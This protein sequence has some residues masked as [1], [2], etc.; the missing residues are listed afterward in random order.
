M[1]AS[2]KVERANAFL[3]RNKNT[4]GAHAKLSPS[5]AHRWV[6]C[7]KSV[8][9]CRKVKRKPT[10]DAAAQGTFLHEVAEYILREVISGRDETLQAGE[11]IGC[12]NGKFTLD[13]DNVGHVSNYVNY[14][15]DT[16]G[17]VGSIAV[18]V[19]LPLKPVTGEDAYGTADC[20][21]YRDGTIHIIDLKTGRVPVSADDNLQLQIYAA[22]AYNAH[23]NGTL[24]T[25]DGKCQKK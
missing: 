9:L 19:R 1:T 13:M 23:I 24:F 16:W 3:Q 14:V 2:T 15:L 25:E 11:L 18:E 22:A 12:T 21:V 8:I 10:S 5:S 17:G 20:V 6:Q 4:S 7:P